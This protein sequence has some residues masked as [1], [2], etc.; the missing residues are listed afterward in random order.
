[1][2]RAQ[3]FA[4]NLYYHELCKGLRALGYEIES[5]TRGFEIKGVPASVVERFSKRHRQI[6]TEAQKRIE[7]AGLRA[8]INTVRRQVARDDRKRKMKDA[9]ADR[10]RPFWGRQLTAEESKA[11]AALKPTAKAAGDRADKR[12]KGV[13]DARRLPAPGDSAFLRSL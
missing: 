1:M 8:D 2:Y 12:G 7:R 10:L 9:T 6:D 5:H 4:E 13:C 3:K 11:L